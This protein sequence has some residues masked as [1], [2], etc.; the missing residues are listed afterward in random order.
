MWGAYMPFGTALA[1]LV[2]P[3]WI[4]HFGWRAWWWALALLTAALAVVTW[5]AVPALRPTAA[6]EGLRRRLTQT[7]RAPGPWLVAMCFAAYSGQWLA[8][9]GFLPAIYTAA[10][11]SGAVT[12]VAS[13][14]AAAVNMAGNIA[15][16]RLL[17]AGVAPTRLLAGGFVVMALA[18]AAAFAQVDGQSLPPLAR[19]A[20][21]LAFS[22]VGG[23]IPATLFSL[24]LRLAPTPAGVATS[25]GWVQQ[26]SAAGQF[27]GP[28][29]VAW[30]AARS[31]GWHW[32]WL[33][34]GCSSLAGL[35]LAAAI[36]R[37]LRRVG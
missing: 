6:G 30:L 3:V 33:A 20:A 19:Y 4:A 1:L 35:V 11:L 21:V 29:L 36:A 27:A 23:V 16:G 13:A 26:W 7:L 15:S 22:A 9:I 10:G 25:I 2:G 31:G 17:H 24:A 5:R 32:T 34:T 14:A 8:V 12:G 37:A 28:P 18:A